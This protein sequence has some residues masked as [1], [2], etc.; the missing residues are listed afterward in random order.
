MIKGITFMGASTW[1]ETTHNPKDAI[2]LTLIQGV[3]RTL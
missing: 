3:E 2:G 1:R